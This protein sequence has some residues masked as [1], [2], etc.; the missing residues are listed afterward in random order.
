MKKLF[1]LAAVSIGFL[2]SA[3][4]EADYYTIEQVSIPD[5]VELE[6]GGMDFLPDGRLAVCTRRGEVFLV[7]DV[8]DRAT[9]ELFARGLHEPL[10]LT[11]HE[12]DIYVAQRGEVTKLLDKDGD[13][14]ADRFETVYEIPLTGNYHEYHY[15]PLFRPDGSFVTTLNV[16]W[17]GKGVSKAKWRGWMLACDPDTKRI[18]PYAVGMRSPA[19]FGLNNEGDIFVAENQGDWIGS[20]RITHLRK[21]DFAG[22]PAGLA[23]TG[24]RNSPLDLE[25]HTIT[26]D[27]GTMY[28]AKR[29]VESLKLPAVWFP[30]GIMGISTAAILNDDTQGAFGP[31]ANQLLV[32]DQGQSKI[33]R[34]SLEKVEGEY[35]GAVFPFR[36]GF[37]S[38]LLRMRLTE[39][40]TLYAGQT[41]RG[42]AATGGEEFALER[43][44]W[45][46]EVPFEMYA[47]TA[48][49][50]GF[51]VA[52]TE[53]IL[54]SS[55]SAKSFTIQN[56]TYR[57]HHNYGSPAVD[58][59]ENAI[60]A[61]RVLSDEK[62]INVKVAG[63]RPGYIY[64]FKIDGITGQ[65]G[66]QLLH[67]VG[68]YTLNNIPG[69]EVAGAGEIG[70][71]LDAGETSP[72]RPT[73]MPTAWNGEVDADILLE[74]IKGMRYK[75]EVL[76]V[77]AGQKVRLTFRN[78]D[79]MQH[80]FVLTSGRKGDAVGEEAA[81][82][83]LKGLGM[84]HVPEMDEV[85]VHTKLVEPETSD[86]IYFVAPTKPGVYEY[87]CTVPG[88]YKIMRGV[89]R[90]T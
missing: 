77:K 34:V 47:I 2:L 68:Y 72:K 86:V 28:A 79:D 9:Y 39:D 74:T 17:E 40:G 5:G 60:L 75:Q 23:W 26:D 12:G 22:H 87:V 33:M 51:N 64:E 62:T 24:E 52:F 73:T 46:G 27:Y 19:G 81:T 1:T 63:L 21:G 71:E 84:S 29:E 49:A 32:S 30:H 82:L 43:L 55:V 4:T 76:Q 69:G 10:G 61:T 6:V 14:W 89:L 78:P 35:Q 44:K 38:G 80:N 15:G 36:E 16:G 58:M 56:F 50:D 70:E 37:S 65:D 53:P 88:H 18:T 41:A 7:S 42:W 8:A 11:V 48:A 67:D 20:G 45:T 3:Q 57:Y 83:G 59:Q 54:A 13:G 66:K 90:V 85:L 31:F 25:A